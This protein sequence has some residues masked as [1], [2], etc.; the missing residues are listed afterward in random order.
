MNIAGKSQSIVR[1]RGKA[2]VGDPDLG[3]F[4]DLPGKWVGLPGRGW[5]LIALPF[6]GGPY[7][8]RLL[9]NRY[10]E[11]LKF[12]EVSKNVPNRGICFEG[13]AVATDQFVATLDY[14]QSITQIKA[15]DEP[16]SGLAGGPAAEIHHEPGLFLY[17]RNQTT[18]NIDI[19]RLA[20]VP[21][22]NTA[23]GLG[24]AKTI[25]GAPEIPPMS[26][27][28][29][30]VAQSLDNE[31]LQPYRHFRDNPFDG[32]FEPTDT[33]ALLRGALAQDVVLSTQILHFDTTLR[34]AGVTNIPFIERQ[35]DASEMQATFW[36]ETLEA[37]DENGDPILQMQ[38]AQT[39]MLDFFP[40]TDGLPGLI[41]WP[42]VSINT[43]RR[44]PGS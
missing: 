17:M 34:A 22:G 18:D 40:R 21:H 43:L 1:S 9:M 36:I 14:E 15:V 38:Y 12:N 16:V 44:M 10:D 6:Q 2:R 24:T 19:A 25:E 35:A 37:Q 30:G 27:L 20:T 26:A 13:T 33:T 31:Y 41:R 28:P 3:P 11:V 8:Y 39:V 42:H 32:L 5:N 29:I 23:L 4:A 7:N